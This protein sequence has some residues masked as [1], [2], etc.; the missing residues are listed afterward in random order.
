MTNNSHLSII[1]P[2]RR[3]MLMSAGAA[4]LLN[5]A[6]A[7]ATPRKKQVSDVHGIRSID[8]NGTLLSYQRH[9][10]RGKRRP[11][12]FGHGYGLRGTGPIYRPLIDQLSQQ[13]DVYALD[14]RGHGASAASFAN[15]SQAA[16]ADDLAAF[17][18]KL[19]L[20]G[21]VYAG[22]SLGGFTGM[23]AQ[24]RHPGTFS[25]LCLLATAAAGGNDA[26]ASVKDAF[27][28]DG[29][30]AAKMRAA[31]GPLYMRPNA[32]DIR[33]AADAVTRLDPSVHEAFYPNF[34]RNIITDQLH[35]ID[36]PVLLINGAMDN[37]VSPAEQHKTA[38]GLKRSK[39]VILSSEGHM[40]PIE[41][42]TV[43]G[44]DIM[45]FL[46]HDISE[47]SA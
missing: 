45:N 46:L 23:F 21:A 40:L 3:Q 37:V 10:G 13:F 2:D 11:L 19:E 16:I 34:G 15:W 26:P 30:D 4:L 25:A 24:I 17:V 7:A 41:A 8:V 27:V 28:R 22:H 38:G 39:E 18:Q 5:G 20:H 44:R 47:V 29:R 31:F 9:A 6:Q 33:L 42:P 32:N 35:E 12:V 36:V 43:V 1:G 14:M